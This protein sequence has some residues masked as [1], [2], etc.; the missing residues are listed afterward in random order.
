[1]YNGRHVLCAILARGGSKGLPGKNVRI[2]ASKPLI[3]HSIDVAKKVKAIDEVVVSTDDGKIKDVSERAGAQVIDRP[4][5]L[6]SDDAS[7]LDAMHHLLAFVGAEKDWIVVSLETT[8]PIRSPEDIEKCIG[9][10]D[11]G[12]DCVGAVVEVKAHPANMLRQK[13]GLMVPFDEH[14][15]VD[16]R[17]TM[18]KLYSYTGSILVATAGFVMGQKRLMYGGKMRGYL[19]D[20]EKYVDIDTQLDFDICEFILKNYG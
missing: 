20:E 4:L 12:T 17:Q 16:N 14:D 2:L 13:E 11:E 10:L 18:D 8:S 5:E 9:M 6:A 7:Y 1:M 3:Q 15:K 19:L